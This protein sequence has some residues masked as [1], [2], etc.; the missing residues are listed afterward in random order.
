MRLGVVLRYV[1]IIMLVVALFMLLS[2][3]VSL[4]SHT[5]SGYYPLLLSA[6]LTA[7][8][9]AFPLIFVDRTEQLSSKEGYCIVV[10]SWIVA[11]VVGMFPY[12]MWGGEFS[13][14]NAWF[15]SVS[16]YTTTGASILKDVEALPR[17]LLFWR[18]CS[19]WL[20]GVGVVMF[21]LLILPSL[22][23]NKALLT[24]VE[25]SSMA[26]HNY[27][28]KASMIAQILLFI[29]LGLT[30]C[31]TLALKLAGMNW[32]DALTQA[33]SA[34]ATSGFSTKN[35]SIGYFDSV[36]VESILIVTMLLASI[37]FGVLFATL[38][39]RRNNIFHSEVTRWYLSIVAARVG[40]RGRQPLFRRGVRHRCG[41]VALCGFSGRVADFDGG[42]RYGRHHR[43]AGDGDRAADFRFDRLRLCRFDDGR[44]QNRPVP[45]GNKD[46]AFAFL[47]TAAS[48]RRG[49]RAYRRQRAGRQDRLDGGGVHRGLF[50]GA[51][52]GNGRGYDVR[53]GY[54]DE[55]LVGGGLYGKRGAWI[56]HG[57][58]AGQLLRPAGR[59]EV[60]EYDVDVAGSFGDFRTRAVVFS[61][62]VE[63]MRKGFF[64]LAVLVAAGAAEASAQEVTARIAGLEGNAE[65]M[66]MLREEAS[67]QAREDSV[68][69][70]VNRVRRQLRDDPA[71]RAVYSAEILRCEEQ[72]FSIR[73]ERGRLTD[74]INTVEQDWVLANL[75][76]SSPSTTTAGRAAGTPL[77]D[78]LQTADLVHN[79]YFREQLPQ[80]D[81]RALLSAQR[82]ER[83]AFDLAAA[84]AANYEA[85]E[86]LKISYDTITAET[87]AAVLYERY[88]TL[89]S[90]NRSLCDSLQRVWGAVYDNKN[91]AYAYVLDRLGR[92]DLLA[93][94][95]EQLAGVRQQMASERGR[96]YADELTDYLLQ[97]RALVDVETELA[98]ALGLTA[99]RDSLARAAAGLRI[100]DYRLPK[101]FIEER[102]FLE[103]EPIGFVTPAKYNASHHIPE[104][105][106][107]ERGTIYRILLGT[108]TNRTNGGYL[109][110]GA[111]PLGYEKVEG[112]YAYYAGGY[113]TLDE[114]R[115]A[116]EQMKK[117]GFRRPEIVVWNDGERT[118]LADAAEQG[119]APMFRVEIGGLDGFPE[120][121]RAA[122]QAVAGESEISRAG[123]HFIVG[124]LADKAVA[125]KVAEAVMQQ[126][127]S[128]EV[129]IVEIV[130]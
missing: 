122:V 92:D 17:G 34:V 73:T 66:E 111:Y 33:M 45:V 5:D 39:G 10:G 3:G 24:N 2:A 98:G 18:S 29:Y 27:H 87:P 127:A 104:V 30:F 20:G 8:L 61:K 26:K 94:T 12:L 63:M 35:A 83:T 102:M 15:E 128:L 116:Q 65:Y 106:V 96:Y 110:K 119:N 23:T 108:Y 99:A 21:A 32:F 124:P 93:K 107:Y 126:N 105:K 68:T 42:I 9:G 81:Y 74:R 69:M 51:A 120:E 38:T 79:A 113:R 7:L 114:A 95:E 4:V 77:P 82:R 121:L 91:Y 11:S 85:I 44:Y 6:L 41:G 117:K 19:T 37:H 76:L 62:M 70:V 52:R 14:V 25:L 80:A 28:Y 16:G 1:G 58:L 115:A 71:Q 100:V 64:L 56:R 22:G 59:D 129:K 130:E 84:C 55:F 48:Q 101:L 109:F 54:G 60:F 78:S 89:Q 31:S 57:R 97:K 43:L 90:L 88:R 75:D 125:D 53:S 118:N 47:F 123:R 72:L 67:L 46:P 86:E 112:K 40:R 36:A 103:Y 50:F 49:A 13:L